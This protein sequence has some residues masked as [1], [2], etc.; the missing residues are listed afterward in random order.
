MPRSHPSRQS[1]SSSFTKFVARLQHTFSIKAS[2]P[3]VQQQPQHRPRSIS[4][5]HHHH[6]HIRLS[7]ILYDPSRQ[8]DYLSDR[9][10]NTTSNSGRSESADETDSCYDSMNDQHRRSQGWNLSQMNVSVDWNASRH[11]Q[12]RRMEKLPNSLHSD[13]FHST[14][15]ADVSEC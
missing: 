12:P 10:D 8:L 11:S 15:I 1:H 7:Q 6:L 4:R 14:A 5:N 3:L 9:D 2:T 13:R